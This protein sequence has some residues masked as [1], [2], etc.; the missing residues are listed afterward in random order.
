MLTTFGQLP[1]N[2]L[3]RDLLKGINPCEC[4]LIRVVKVDTQLEC[5]ISMNIFIN[6]YFQLP[7]RKM[8]LNIW[9][10]GCAQVHMVI[11]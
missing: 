3:L 7:N 6:Q 2:R 5:N 1:L 4:I 9:L 11:D 8:C 10:Q